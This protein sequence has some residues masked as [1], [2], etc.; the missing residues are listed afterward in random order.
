MPGDSTK[1][2]ALLRSGT[3]SAEQVTIIGRTPPIASEMIKII[4]S[5]L[6]LLNQAKGVYLARHNSVN[7]GANDWIV[8]VYPAGSTPTR[9]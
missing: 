1:Y 7:D 2:S 9:R 4:E 6:P 8:M 3:V 5:I